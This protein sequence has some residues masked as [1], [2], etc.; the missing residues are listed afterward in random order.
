[1][2]SSPP[3]RMSRSGSGMKLVARCWLMVSSVMSSARMPPVFIFLKIF[4]G[5]SSMSCTSETICLTAS[6]ISHLDE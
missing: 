4:S 6:V 1:M 2:R 3:V 5:S